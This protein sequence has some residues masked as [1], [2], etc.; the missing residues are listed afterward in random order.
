MPYIQL[1]EFDTR[2]KTEDVRGAMD[3][4]L[5]AT[6]GQRALRMAVVAADH[7]RPNHYWEL[8]EFASEEDAA[9]NA[10]LPE[11]KAAFEKWSSLLEGEPTFHNLDVV[12]QVGGTD[13]SPSPGLAPWR[14]PGGG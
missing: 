13:D 2:H 10:E 5:D 1:V 8:L 4:W 7:D 9:K 6:R 11:T 3:A 12:E 14:T